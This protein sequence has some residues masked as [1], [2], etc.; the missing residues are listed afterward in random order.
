MSHNVVWE[1]IPGSQVDFMSCPF[2]EVLFEGGRGNGKTDSLLMDYAQFV[3]RGYGEEWRGILLRETYPNLEDVIN[4]SLKWFTQI[5]PDAFYNSSDH[6]W[7]FSTG[8]KLYFRHAEK[9]S[10]YWKYHGHAYPWVGWEEL[11]NWQTDELYLK[12]MSVCRST[13]PDMPRR[14]RSTT[15]PLG[16]G[17]GWVKKRFIDPAPANTVMIDDSGRKR[18]RITGHIEENHFLMDN[19]PD[20]VKNLE[21]QPE[22]IVKAWRHGSWDIQVGGYVTDLWDK[23]FHVMERFKIPSNWYIDRTFDWG[24]SHPYAVCW[25]AE[26]DGSDYQLPSGEW[27]PTIAGD[28][29]LIHELYGGKDNVGFKESTEVT[30]D[31]IKAIEEALG[32]DIS[33]GA[34]DSAIFADNAGHS[35]IN[36]Y[37]NND[38]YWTKCIKYPGSRINNAKL[39]RDRLEASINRDGK[40][41]IFVFDH[42]REFIR[43]IPM[44][45]W[46][47][48]KLEDVDTNGDDHLFD[49]CCYRLSSNGRCEISSGSAG[50]VG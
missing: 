45:L 36:D 8:E 42:C 37:V 19:D 3:G 15:N 1:P 22:H 40:P 48:K 25:W 30:C 44:L 21:A 32:Y 9:A 5:F 20:Y 29:F 6:V 18:I 12:M 39:F 31:K 26:S 24:S 13:H 33:A 10:D 4:K 27:R 50:N 16:K 17:F 14:Y 41:G 28:L 34:A 49:A 35:I 23:D 11:T 43:T 2:F 7:K 38:V 46:D 47:E